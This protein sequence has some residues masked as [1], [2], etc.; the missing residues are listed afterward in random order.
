MAERRK[1]IIDIVARTSGAQKGVAGLQRNMSSLNKGSVKANKS[2]GGISKSTASAKR[3]LGSLVGGA[4]GAGLAMTG[5]GAAVLATG[6]IIKGSVGAFASFD[7][8]MNQSVAIMGDVSDAMRNDMSMA[9]REMAKTTRFSADE[10]A[11]SYFF[12][13]SAGLDAEQSIAAL[14]AVAAFGQAG[15]FDMALATDLLTDAQSSLGL[16]TDDAST[17]LANMTRVSDVF[18]KANT[19][20]NTSVQQVSEAITNKLGGALRG[21]N[22]DIEEGVAVLAAYADQGLKGASAG[23]A[24]NIVLRD[25]KKVGRESADVLAEHNI[26]IFDAEGNFNNMADVVEDLEDAFEGLTVAE[27]AQ[28]AADLGFQDRSFKNI[29]LL[30][31]QSDAIR[32]YEGELRKAGGTTE[33]VAGKQMESFSAQM[34]LLKSRVVDAGI[35]LGEALA[36]VVLEIA[37]GFLDMLEAI[38]PLIS[39]A[40]TLFKVLFKFSGLAFAF[41]F[42]AAAGKGFS[43]LSGLWDENARA[44]NTMTAAIEGINKAAEEGTSPYD[45]LADSIQHVGITGDLTTESLTELMMASGLNSSE[46]FDAIKI[47][48]DLAE[49]NN[50]TAKEV[51]ALKDAMLEGIEASNLDE[52]AKEALIEEYGL[53]EVITDRARAHTEGVTGATEAL[54]D[55]EGNLVD[56][57]GRLIDATGALIDSMG[58]LVDEEGNVIVE[59]LSLA[60]ALALAEENQQSLADTMRAFADPLFAAAQAMKGLIEAE[61]N[62][63]DVQGDAEATAEDL[64]DAELA[65]LDALLKTQGGLDAL[66]AAGLE[67][68]LLIVQDGLGKSREE[69]ILFLDSLNLLDGSQIELGV[70][71]V[72]T[73]SGTPAAIRAGG[74]GGGDSAAGTGRK[75]GGPVT[76]GGAFI[77][78]EEGPE[79]FVPGKSGMIVPNNAL[80]GM[81][82]NNNNQ[83]RNLQV[84]FN[85]PQL[86][87]NPVSGVRAAFARDR[88]QKV[89]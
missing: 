15:M 64:A 62:L 40:A 37:S 50:L 81:T 13:A 61:Q 10:A 12:L 11:E 83:Q 66:D 27:Q 51:R 18:V 25:L 79:L 24:F 35:S 42:L 53:L 60:E 59:T 16:T 71:T 21:A 43:I 22:I 9:A 69:A 78:G 4:G 49:A 30:I 74:G 6:A 38:M 48:L 2:L 5:V 58:N 1:V 65:V 52:D 47:N 36:P 44:A 20:A 88:M 29:Q 26:E 17:N 86:A 23:E 8:K 39:G 28:L 3:G 57:E 76:A 89:A 80:A 67:D 55:E 63:I 41:K 77:V 75:H 46:A 32:E 85:N 72:F 45:A 19:L 33:E 84:V 54:V 34:G 82:T 73:S 14:P 56:S 7:D 87:N 70:N 68:M 31:G